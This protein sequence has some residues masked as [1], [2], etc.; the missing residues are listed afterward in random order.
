MNVIAL[1]SVGVD[2]EGVPYNQQSLNQI[3]KLIN[4]LGF[5]VRVLTDTPNV[6]SEIGCI[7]YQYN[8]K[9]FNYF[10]KLFFSIKLA[11]DLN[12]D[13]LYIDIDN[14]WYLTETDEFLNLHSSDSVLFVEHWPTYVR[15][16]LE[17]WKYLTDLN[18]E[19][20]T[21]PLVEYL[22]TEGKDP[23][24][25]DTIFERLLYF[26]AGLDWDCV[27]YQLEKIKPV[28]DYMSLFAKDLTNRTIYGHG[29]GLALS[30]ALSECD[31]KKEL[32]KD[33]NN[34]ESDIY[35]KQLI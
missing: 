29:E 27:E 32:I 14:L 4:E 31:I 6:F 17:S 5:E 24:Q 12:T 33:Q 2:N 16:Y 26:P 35:K 10:D 13:V 1:V 15:G 9:I 25:L 3:S 11:K 28:F 20:W 23:S 7:T 30:Y 34:T 21:Y 22:K 19:K 18:I 8:N